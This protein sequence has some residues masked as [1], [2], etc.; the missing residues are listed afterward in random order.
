LLSQ[1]RRSFPFQSYLIVVAKQQNNNALEISINHNHQ[2]SHQ[3]HE[4]I[5]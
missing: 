2:S 4:Q 5:R 1:L 3:L